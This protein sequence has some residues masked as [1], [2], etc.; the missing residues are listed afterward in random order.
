M[1]G[2]RFSDAASWYTG[3]ALIYSYDLFGR[4]LV[5]SVIG[6]FQ[7]SVMMV[8][9]FWDMFSIGTE[10]SNAMTLFP[11]ISWVL[12]SKGAG[13]YLGEAIKNGVLNEFTEMLSNFYSFAT[14]LT[15]LIF[16]ISYLAS[17]ILTIKSFTG[18]FA[19][20]LPP[21]YSESLHQ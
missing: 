14:F 5:V 18:H 21:Y 16:S 19:L 3:Y 4:V 15:F 2:V 6:L 11:L 17:I 13:E 12:W 1:E 7:N 9:F 8:I 10:W 20:T